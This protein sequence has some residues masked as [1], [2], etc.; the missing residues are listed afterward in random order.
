MNIYRVNTT[1]YAEE[2]FYLMTTI[3]AE[4]V[5]YVLSPMVEKE[6][7]SDDLYDIVDLVDALRKACPTDEVN[8][9]YEI[10]RIVI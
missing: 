10:E 4:M 1:A 3:S 6:R 7:E 5:E 8:L 2:D 9:I